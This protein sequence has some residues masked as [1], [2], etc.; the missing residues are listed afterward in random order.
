[1]N[2]RKG[3]PAFAAALAMIF[4][5]ALASAHNGI[6]HITGTVSAISSTSVT[7]KNVQNESVTVL[8]D[9]S[10]TFTKN[11]VK[12]SWQELKVGEHVLVNAKDNA[13]DKLVGITVRWGANAAAHPE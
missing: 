8:L 10:T 1:M 7:V 11:N 12:A 6:E 9:H 4:G 13:Q 2:S 3:L 5:S